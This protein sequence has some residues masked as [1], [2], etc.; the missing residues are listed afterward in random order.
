MRR[1]YPQVLRRSPHGRGLGGAMGLYMY[2]YTCVQ[3]QTVVES[4][5]GPQ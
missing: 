1:I 5:L 2:F 4:M 3:A